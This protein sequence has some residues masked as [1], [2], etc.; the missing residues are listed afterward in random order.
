[1]VQKHVVHVAQADAENHHSPEGA[2]AIQC[3]RIAA[4]NAQRRMIGCIGGKFSTFCPC[5]ILSP[6]PE[7]IT[8]RYAVALR[9][10]PQSS[11]SGA[12]ETSEVSPGKV[13]RLRRTVLPGIRELHRV[14]DEWRLRDPEK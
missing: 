11:V 13:W 5:V 10:F 8:V 12:E 1:V 6:A 3:V 7:V 9:E 4:A 14:L 2:A